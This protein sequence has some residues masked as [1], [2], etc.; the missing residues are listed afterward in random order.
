MPGIPIVGGGGTA[1]HSTVAAV[2]MFD[3]TG[4]WLSFMVMIWLAELEFPQS[5]VAVQVRV[6]MN[7]PVQIPAVFTSD[8]R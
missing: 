1:S 6:K 4:G 8:V 5:S 2:G 3:K 7:S